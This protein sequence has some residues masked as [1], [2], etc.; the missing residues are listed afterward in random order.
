MLQQCTW[1][2]LKLHITNVLITKPAS[3]KSPNQYQDLYHS[4]I[5][6]YFCWLSAQAWYG[7]LEFNVPLNT[8]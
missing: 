8:V 5:S 4:E 6:G 2:L 1:G 3:Q 7:I